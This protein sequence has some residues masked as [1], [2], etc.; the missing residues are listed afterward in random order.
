MWV[1]DLQFLFELGCRDFVMGSTWFGS[2]CKC[3]KDLSTR[4]KILSYYLWITTPIHN[5]SCIK[6]VAYSRLVPTGSG[7]CIFLRQQQKQPFISKKASAEEI[8]T[9]YLK[10]IFFLM[11]DCLCHWASYQKHITYR[12]QLRLMS[13]DVI[14]VQ[15]TWRWPSLHGFFSYNGHNSKP[16]RMKMRCNFQNNFLVNC[17]FLNLPP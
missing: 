12:K 17:N 10:K 6:W 13:L 8:C 7:S 2:S 5:H 9:K 15:L 16:E 14:W 4:F 3:T 11:V 1:A